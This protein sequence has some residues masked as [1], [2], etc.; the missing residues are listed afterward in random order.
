MKVYLAQHDEPNQCLVTWCI[1]NDEYIVY[2][3]SDSRTFSNS[4][5][6]AHFYG[7]CIAHSLACANKLINKLT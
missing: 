1:L 5:E 6:A 7:E 4:I 3:G 2:Y